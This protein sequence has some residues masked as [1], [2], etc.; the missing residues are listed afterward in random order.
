MFGVIFDHG[1]AFP[2][3]RRATVVLNHHEG[4]LFHLFREIRQQDGVER[5]LFAHL[6]ALDDDHQVR[7][8][9]RIVLQVLIFGG[10]EAVHGA[11][12]DEKFARA[13]EPG[14]IVAQHL[15]ILD[16]EDEFLFVHG[17]L[18][19]ATLGGDGLLEKLQR[20]EGRV[21][22]AVDYPDGPFHRHLLGHD[23][24]VYYMGALRV[25]TH[26]IAVIGFGAVTR[27]EGHDGETLAVPFFGIG[28]VDLHIGF[29]EGVDVALHIG[30][31][32]FGA[33]SVG[34]V[35]GEQ[36]PQRRLVAGGLGRTGLRRIAHA[37]PRCGEEFGEAVFFVVT[38]SGRGTYGIKD[39]VEMFRLERKVGENLGDVRQ[40]KQ[41]L[42]LFGKVQLVFLPGAGGEGK[43]AQQPG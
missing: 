24:G 23:H 26:F 33:V 4:D 11:C 13:P 25:D 15:E 9:G 29:A 30:C 2:A 5:D 42:G 35:I 19:L 39:L 32:G 27:V 43:G 14:V 36:V 8:A 41:I 7:Q 12:L 20:G 10:L 1:A 37:R 18:V 28:P 34:E 31:T 22:V 17:G 38:V 21:A 40:G 3:C 16:A 6:A